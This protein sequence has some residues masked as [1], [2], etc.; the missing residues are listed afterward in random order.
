MKNNKDH[1]RKIL[2]KLKNSITQLKNGKEIIA[3][4]KLLGVYQELDKLYNILSEEDSKKKNS[5]SDKMVKY[6]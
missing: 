6:G 1:V 5:E 3:Y 2:I 4:N